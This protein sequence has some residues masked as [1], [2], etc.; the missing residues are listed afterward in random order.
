M[1]LKFLQSTRFWKVVVVA[2]LAT[3]QSE[4]LVPEGLWANLST[5]IEVVFGV[6][7]VVRTID[8]SVEKLGG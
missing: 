8:R 4:G 2:V 1:D 6:S 7:V 5:I 3:L